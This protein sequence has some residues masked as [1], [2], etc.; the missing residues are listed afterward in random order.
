[1][2]RE[3]LL[4]L[5]E[6]RTR[7]AARAQDE[8]EALASMLAPVDAAAALAGSATRLAG[9]L[10]GQ[11][12]RYPWFVAAGV[13]L[14]AALRPRRALVWFSR[15]WSLWRLYRGAQGMYQRFAG[16]GAAAPRRPA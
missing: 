14:L 10:A 7:L 2:M 8:R 1:M 12:A 5:A 4:G 15:G 11:A 16:P 6:H 3:R 13:A 9:G